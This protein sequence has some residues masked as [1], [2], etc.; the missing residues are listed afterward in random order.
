[1][2]NRILPQSLL[3]L[4]SAYS[5]LDICVSSTTP[6]WAEK[7]PKL[8]DPCDGNEECGLGMC[9][10][11]HYANNRTVCEKLSQLNDQCSETRL[12]EHTHTTVP[13][14]PF[15]RVDDGANE[16]PKQ[17]YTH[18]YDKHCP[19]EHRL[20]CSFDA[21]KSLE[22]NATKDNVQIGKCVNKT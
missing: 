13:P 22:E 10:V 21:P 2:A 9:C 16:K 1:M 14:I 12:K 4:F 11:R 5:I 15:C 20:T 8:G 17:N 7:V 19:C 3:L 18:P 6:A